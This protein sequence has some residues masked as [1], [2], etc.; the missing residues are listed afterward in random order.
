MKYPLIS[1]YKEA[2]L[3]AEANFS[4][5]SN[6]RPVLDANGGPVMVNGDISVVFKMTDG[7]KDYA[8]K[9]FLT[10]QEGREDT[11]KRICKY[12]SLI[13]PP[14]MVNTEYLG[15]ELR[16][17]AN[18]SS[19]QKYPVVVMDWV[20]GMSLAQYMKPYRVKR[21]NAYNWLMNSVS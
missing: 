21:R 1:E 2:I 5:L 7:E 11:Y 16:V 18:H 10:D 8:V 17:G 12:L 9:C 19:E 13:Q 14:Y 4:K 6:L 15:N 20:E 3:N